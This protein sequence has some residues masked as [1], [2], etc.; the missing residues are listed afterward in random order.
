MLM[1]AD[2]QGVGVTDAILSL[3]ELL[4]LSIVEFKF[5]VLF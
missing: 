5:L 2:C 4:T 1:F 3:T